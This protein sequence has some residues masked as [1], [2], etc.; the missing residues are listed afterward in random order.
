METCKF[1]TTEWIAAKNSYRMMLESASY[2][3]FTVRIPLQT[4]PEQFQRLLALQRAFAGVCNAIVPTVARTRV[5]NRVA[6]HHMTYRQLREQFPALGSQM[7]CNAIYAV[8]RMSRT[9][10]QHPASPFCA[11]WKPARCTLTATP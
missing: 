1:V 4:T 11:S 6:L 9:V 10:Y 8:S 2:M 7:V 5:W 3:K